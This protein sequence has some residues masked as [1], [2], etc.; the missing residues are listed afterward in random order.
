MSFTGDTDPRMAR[1]PTVLTERI[2]KHLSNYVSGFAGVSVMSPD[3]V[4]PMSVIAK[5]CESF[6][7]KIGAE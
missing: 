3:V 4:V 7:G 5:W 2:V 1:D 6:M